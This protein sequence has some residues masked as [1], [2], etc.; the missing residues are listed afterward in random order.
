MKQLARILIVIA[1]SVG[2]SVPVI[3]ANINGVEI[4]TQNTGGVWWTGSEAAIGIT[5]SGATNNPFYNGSDPTNTSA[6]PSPGI[7]SG[8]YLAFMGYENYWPITDYATLT[9]YYDDATS[10]SATFRVGSLTNSGAWDKISGDSLQLGGGGFDT[11]PDRVGTHGNSAITPLDGI[12]DVVLMFSDTGGLSSTV[13][14]PA[15]MLLLGVGLVGVAGLRRRFK[16]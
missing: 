6:I 14:E 4:T 7:S 1:I 13:P 10:K 3:A 2:L 9:L 8:T 16:K 5:D 12:P 11:T 15:T